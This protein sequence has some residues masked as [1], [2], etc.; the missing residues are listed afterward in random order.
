MPCP[1]LVRFAPA[2][3]QHAALIDH[4]HYSYQKSARQTNGITPYGLPGSVPLD[5]THGNPGR[6]RSRPKRGAGRGRRAVDPG[7]A[8]DEKLL[9]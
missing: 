5:V 8:L 4:G 7:Q 1:A 6:H 9:E 3:P 2:I